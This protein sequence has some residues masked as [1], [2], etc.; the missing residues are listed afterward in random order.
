[1]ALISQADYKILTESLR[2]ARCLAVSKTRS[3]SDII[4]LHNYGQVDFAENYSQE[5]QKKAIF[6]SDYNINWHF[7]G[8]IQANKCKIIACYADWVHSINSL[9]QLSLLS[10]YRPVDKPPLNC[11]LQVLPDYIQHDYAIPLSQVNRFLLNFPNI[12]IIG[13]MVMP[14]S[15]AGRVELEQIF[16]AVSELAHAVW[17]CPEIS[18]GMS[19]DYPLAVEHNATIVRLGR[20]LFGA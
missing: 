5:L 14:P 4:S 19:S 20:A 13:F 15:C 12:N 11:L 2:F 18:M 1:M 3:E 8:R 7:I 6:F 10:K 9:D 17:P 16:A